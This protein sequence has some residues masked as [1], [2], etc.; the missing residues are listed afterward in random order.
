[1]AVESV[2]DETMLSTTL[3]DGLF[4]GWGAEIG[5]IIPSSIHV[6]VNGKTVPHT[7]DE[8]SRVLK[9]IPGELSDDAVVELRFM[10]IYK[11]SNHPQRYRV[12]RSEEGAM[13]APLGRP[14]PQTPT[15]GPMHPEAPV[16]TTRPVGSQELLQPPPRQD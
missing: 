15:T 13:L 5:R 16:G 14:R 11:H 10:N 3:D 4:G 7:F 6:R 9:A 2:A 12:I 8:K 1:P